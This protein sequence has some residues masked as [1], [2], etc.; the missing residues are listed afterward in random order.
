MTVFLKLYA[1]D[2]VSQRSIRP[3]W[4]NYKMLSK[5]LRKLQKKYEL[6]DNF[7]DFDSSQINL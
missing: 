7:K 6:E 2:C 4:G 5:I 1:K 3:Y